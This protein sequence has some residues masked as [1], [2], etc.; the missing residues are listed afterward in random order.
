MYSV[1]EAKCVTMASAGAHPGLGDGS[2]GGCCRKKGF[3]GHRVEIRVWRHLRTTLTSAL[4]AKT[5]LGDASMASGARSLQLYQVSIC[6]V[7]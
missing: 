4:A 7:G 5:S 1:E 6:T 2:M 3:Q